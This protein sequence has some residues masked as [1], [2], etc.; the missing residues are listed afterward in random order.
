MFILDERQEY[1]KLNIRDNDLKMLIKTDIINKY[2]LITN[3]IIKRNNLEKKNNTVLN[4]NE[5]TI[6]LM[7]QK[8]SN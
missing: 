6:K 1:I 8:V 7:Q 2:K 3:R 5:V 4:S